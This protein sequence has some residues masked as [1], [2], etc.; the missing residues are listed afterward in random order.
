[1]F[2]VYMEVIKKEQKDKA[3]LSYWEKSA[4]RVHFAYCNMYSTLIKTG[5]LGMFRRK[6][7]TP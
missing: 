7:Q 2:M 6:G 4:G 5:M 1:M 3:L